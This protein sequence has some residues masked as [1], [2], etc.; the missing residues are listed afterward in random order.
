M[1]ICDV[2][3]QP[4]E[5]ADD[6]DIIEL[7][8]EGQ[9]FFASV[10]EKKSTSILHNLEKSILE[11]PGKR[12]VIHLYQKSDLIKATLAFSHASR[13]AITTGFP[14]HTDGLPGALSLCQA[15][16][17]LGKD[18]SLICDSEN[19]KSLFESCVECVRREGGPRLPVKILPFSKAMEMWEG[20]DLDAPPWDCLVAIKRAG[21]G[22]D[23][24]YRTVN[25]VPESVEPVDD[26]FLKALSNP[27]V[28]TIAIGDSGNELGMG[29]VYKQVV[30][31]I[32]RG[33]TI[34]STTSTDFLIACGVSDWAGY[35]LSMGLYVVSSSPVHW[36]YRN[37][38]INANQ[39][40]QLDRTD[41]IPTMS[42]VN[43]HLYYKRTSYY[44]F[45][46]WCS[47]FL[48]YRLILC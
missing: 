3:P 46:L 33:D 34:A 11:D 16:V 17:V 21:R 24:V 9:P 31:Y 6:I 15:L 35:A 8:R 18:V 45:P 23:E 25:A 7:S 4:E 32:S 2:Q 48:L 13:V 10:V 20:A 19:E 36:R 22:R 39:A 41:F 27:L 26:L 5:L 12:G 38:G 43:R 47:F 40:P 30:K 42:Q 28:S 37:H 44:F 29:K 14:V 1:F